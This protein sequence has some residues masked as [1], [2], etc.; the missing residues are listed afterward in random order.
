MI[1]EWILKKKTFVKFFYWLK[2]TNNPSYNLILKYQIQTKP[3]F[4]SIHVDLLF[5]GVSH[6]FFL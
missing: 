1:D 2:Q 3:F 6:E 5:Y 4:L